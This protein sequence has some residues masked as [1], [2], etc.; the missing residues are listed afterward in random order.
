MNSILCNQQYGFRKNK[1]TNYPIVELVDKI[2]KAIENDQYTIG[3]FLDLSKAFD[4]VNHSILLDKLCF[5]GIRGTKN[6]LTNRKQIIKFNNSKS[7]EKT[8]TCGVPQGSILRPLLFLLYINDIINSSKY[9][10]YILFA[11]TNIYCSGKDLRDL[12]TKLNE[13]LISVRRVDD[14]KS[15]DIKYKKITL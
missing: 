9:L 4:T 12:E 15:I 6:Y 8:I 3:V 10:S 7:Q 5:Y 1:S 13:E 11:D 14:L 2:T